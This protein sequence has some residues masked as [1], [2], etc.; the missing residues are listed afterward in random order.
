[1]IHDFEKKHHTDFDFNVLNGGLITGDRV[2]PIGPMAE[3]ILSAIPRLEEMT[4]MKVGESYKEILRD[5][6]RVM[7]SLPPATAFHILTEL[8]PDRQIE[9]A[10]TM[11]HLQFVEGIDMS[12]E[13]GLLNLVNHFPIDQA[14]FLKKLN[15]ET[16][17]KQAL[18]EFAE[19][20][21]MG[22][23]GYPAVVLNRGDAYIALSRGYI[24]A[25]ALESN[26]QSALEY[27]N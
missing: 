11:Q 20:S 10:H 15:S 27:K 19:V 24:S 2:G 1:V 21:G 22:I 4:G 25:T 26:L 8:Y 9:L 6:K 16:Y 17:R 3:Y 14:E 18:Q 12:S 7:D 5:G 13:T 23:S